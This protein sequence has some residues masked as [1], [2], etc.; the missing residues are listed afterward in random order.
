[1]ANQRACALRTNQTDTERRL[2]RQLRQLKPLGFHSAAKFRSSI[3]LSTSH[4]FSAR[5]VIEVDGG[6]HNL[7]T[8]ARV[9]KLRDDH[10]RQHGFRVLRFWNN[11]VMKNLDGVTHEISSALS[12][13]D[14]HPTPSP[15]G[16]LA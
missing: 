16:G 11:D 1:M 4:V 13:H 3:S 15:Q 7:A 8:G 9:D 2:W 12:V 14:P 10:L 5:L 6:R